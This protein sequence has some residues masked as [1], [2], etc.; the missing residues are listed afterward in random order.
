MKLNKTTLERIIKEELESIREQKNE[1]QVLNEHF[2]A[3]LDELLREAAEEG[4]AARLRSLGGQGGSLASRFLSQPMQKFWEMLKKTMSKASRNRK[5]E[6]M[7]DM[8]TDLDISP[9]ELTTVR[10]QVQQAQRETPPVAADS[11]VP[12]VNPLKVP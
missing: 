11:D 3:Q 12:V 5:I 4:L 1:D 10:T 9:S 7:R 6:M 2:Q 8:M